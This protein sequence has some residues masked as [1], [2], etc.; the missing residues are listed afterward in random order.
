V[1]SRCIELRKLRTAKSAAAD[2]LNQ[3]EFFFLNKNSA[4]R[5]W[6]AAL[7]RLE[8]PKLAHLGADSEGKKYLLVSGL[9]LAGQKFRPRRPSPMSPIGRNLDPIWIYCGHNQV[10][11]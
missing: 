7:L 11:F 5:L 8:R 3:T 1:K 10:S 6:R 2:F 9:R 4:S